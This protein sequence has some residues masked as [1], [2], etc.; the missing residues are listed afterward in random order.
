METEKKGI[1]RVLERRR[2]GLEKLFRR[3]SLP[4]DHRFFDPAL[5]LWA[6]TLEANWRAI[7]QELDAI[8]KE[9]EALPS[10]QQVSSR[11]G[12]ISPDDKW[13][14]FFFYGYGYKAEKNCNRCPRTTE[15]IEAVPGMQTAFFSILAPGKH[16]P[17]HRG[18]Y[19]GVLRYHLGLKVPTR[20]EHCRIRVEEEYAHWEEGRSLLFDDTYEH[21]VWNDTDEE[22]VV[23]FLD[24][25]RP[26]PLPVALLNR[27]IIRAAGLLP[28]VQEVRKKQ[29]L[30]DLVRS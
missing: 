15:L 26:L 19:P 13:K 20:R 4:G 18:P 16:I 2:G 22:R 11:Q 8:L 3:F 29:D 9:R 5:F 30:L 28:D 12:R 10:F 6:Q 17:A 25:L 23:L 21:E 27:G 7:R 14:V 1:Q 24:V